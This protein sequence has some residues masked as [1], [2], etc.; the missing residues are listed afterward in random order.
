MATRKK[1]FRSCVELEK[2]IFKRSVDT[3]LNK[4]NGQLVVDDELI[5][6]KSR[7][8]ESKYVTK[9]KKGKEGFVTDCVACS[10]SNVILECD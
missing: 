5:A 8:V 9:R 7:D 3:F 2:I 1:Q 10:L 4:T 6:L